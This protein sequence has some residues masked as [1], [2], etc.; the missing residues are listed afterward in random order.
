[1]FKT[2]EDIDGRCTCGRV[3]GGSRRGALSW[4]DTVRERRRLRLIDLKVRYL[5]DDGQRK[6]EW[7]I[8]RELPVCFTVPVRF[9]RH[10]KILHKSSDRNEITNEQEKKQK[11]KMK[12]Q[13]ERNLWKGNKAAKV[14]INAGEKWLRQH[15]KTTHIRLLNHSVWEI[16]KLG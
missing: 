15:T 8:F 10:T 3:G 16:L 6:Q 7:H 4:R 12:N 13:K 14:E 2:L 9:H 5:W 11:P 1:M